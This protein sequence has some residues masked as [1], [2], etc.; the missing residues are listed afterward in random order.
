MEVDAGQ[1]AAAE[2]SLIA[3]SEPCLLQNSRS[4]TG[5]PEPAGSTGYSLRNDMSETHPQ[6]Q[7]GGD[8]DLA[9]RGR[10]EVNA[11]AATLI[12]KGALGGNSP[13]QVCQP[14]SALSCTRLE[15][16]PGPVLRKGS[17][18]PASGSDQCPKKLGTCRCAMRRGALTRPPGRSPRSYRTRSPISTQNGSGLRTPSTTACRTETPVSTSVRPE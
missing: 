18:D 8:G 5:F 9:D 10:L 12:D 1:M 4:P 2:P 3:Q 13:D 16:R 6:N 14:I 7:S 17:L 11:D 15:T